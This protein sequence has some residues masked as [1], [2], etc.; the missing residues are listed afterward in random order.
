[1]DRSS[2]EDRDYP[3]M[4][5]YMML[6]KLERWLRWK[7]SKDIVSDELFGSFKVEAQKLKALVKE[8]FDVSCKT[9][10]STSRFHML[11]PL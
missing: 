4:H 8:M 7:H 11:D 2:G 6:S 3:M 5:V 1:M 9:R 10:L